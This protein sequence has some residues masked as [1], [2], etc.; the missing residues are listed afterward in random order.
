MYKAHQVI[1]GSSPS[2]VT[3]WNSGGTVPEAWNQVKHVSHRGAINKKKID[4]YNNLMLKLQFEFPGLLCFN[5]ID[6][7]STKF[8]KLI[9]III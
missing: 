1:T 6:N 3:V 8:D 5:M 9:I 2:S 7:L 4:T